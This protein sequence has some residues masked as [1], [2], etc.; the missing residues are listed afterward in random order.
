MSDELD[1]LWEILDLIPEGIKKITEIQK[2][3]TEYQKSVIAANEDIKGPDKSVG[4]TVVQPSQTS[5]P[6]ENVVDLEFS[7]DGVY[8]PRRA[9]LEEKI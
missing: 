2:S 3:I 9:K 8:R 1:F 5:T 4:N 7:S 6:P